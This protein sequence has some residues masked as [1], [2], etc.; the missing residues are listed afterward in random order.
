MRDS[1]ADGYTRVT[2]PHISLPLRRASEREPPFT[3][4]PPTLTLS[5]PL[6]HTLTLSPLTLSLRTHA[7][8]FTSR[9]PLVRHLPPMEG[10]RRRLGG[11]DGARRLVARRRL[12]RHARKGGRVRG[13]HIPSLGA[14]PRVWSTQW[15]PRQ[16]RGAREP[17]LFI[18]TIR[19]WRVGYSC[20]HRACV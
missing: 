4:P 1:L 5:H 6:S 16:G 20:A 11:V 12:P 7:T 13:S 2:T 9:R 3:P 10:A 17:I 8:L 18:D 19:A 15:W 14:G